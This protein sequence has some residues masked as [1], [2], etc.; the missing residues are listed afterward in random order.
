M[1]KIILITALVTCMA[2][3]S[4]NQKAEEN[5]T[6]TIA[7]EVQ[8]LE[9]TTLKDRQKLEDDNKKVVAD[10]YQSL[11]GDKDL[12]A[13]DKYIDEGYIQHNPTVAD[14]RTAFKEA[15]SHWFVDAPKEKI[16]IQHI[17]ADGDFVYIHLKNKEQGKV[18]SVI[19]IFKLKDGKIMEHWDV[20][21]DVPAKAANEHP[22][23]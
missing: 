20:M 8:N 4:C 13:I 1:R 22:M 11:F 5:T 7:T 3:V 15:A 2:F 12:T 16:D 21:Q 19:D 14:G 18:T 6:S 10:F 17:G 23:F 9:L